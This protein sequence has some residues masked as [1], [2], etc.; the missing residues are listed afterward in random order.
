MTARDSG[1]VSALVS[2][3]MAAGSF[4]GGAFDVLPE[5][6]HFGG[7]SRFRLHLLQSSFARAFARH[8]E[9]DHP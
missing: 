9:R 6:P 4:S 2:G 7:R 3:E 1:G 5:E 8:E